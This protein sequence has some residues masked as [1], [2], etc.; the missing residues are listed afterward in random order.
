MP[1]YKTP[2]S[3]RRRQIFLE[4][5]VTTAQSDQARGITFLSPDT[6][7]EMEAFLPLFAAQRQVV[8][9]SKV[10]F[11]QARTNRKTA[12]SDLKRQLRD[13]WAV[14]RRM[15]RRGDL[16]AEAL[17]HYGLAGNGRNPR[18]D[19]IAAVLS[20]AQTAISGDAEAVSAGLNP[21]INP[22]AANLQTA[23]TA[24]LAQDTAVQEAERLYDNAQAALAELRQAA[25]RLIH[26]VVYELR[27]NL[28]DQSAASRRRVM[29]SYGVEFT[30]S[31]GEEA[32]P[33][34]GD[35]PPESEVLAETIMTEISENGVNEYA[36]DDTAVLVPAGTNGS[37]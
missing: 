5:A 26:K 23:L 11:R 14:A 6:L 29:R 17:T 30:P 18:H 4:K 28:H 10:V 27:F 37:F 9:T 31:P 34:D 7:A 15:A 22:A 24:A 35:L 20:Y 13:F 25:N 8:P 2:S 16:P 19:K 36:M 32:E 21:V 3:D 33:E 1:T 12:V